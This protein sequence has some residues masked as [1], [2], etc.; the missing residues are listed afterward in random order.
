MKAE[1]VR[2]TSVIITSA[3]SD[4]LFAEMV[5]AI[6]MKDAMKIAIFL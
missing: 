4:I 2:Q 1:N 5:F 6:R 3:L